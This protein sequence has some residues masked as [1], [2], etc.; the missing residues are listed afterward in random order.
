MADIVFRRTGIVTRGGAVMG[1]LTIGTKTWPTVEKSGCPWVRKGTYTLMR[2][3][4]VSGRAVPCLSFHDS[5]AINRIL[6]HD[7]NEDNHNDLAGCIAPGLTA[8]EK[9]IQGS[10]KA[11]EQ[12]LAELKVEMWGKVTIEVENNLWGTETKEAWIKSREAAH[13]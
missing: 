2:C 6:I 11:M 4:K 5:K 9:G 1:E 7:A 3:T 13:K 8:H 10:D 12:I